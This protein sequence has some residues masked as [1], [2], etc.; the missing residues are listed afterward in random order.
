MQWQLGCAGAAGLC[1]YMD[2]TLVLIGVGP[3]RG[4]SFRQAGGLHMGSAIPCTDPRRCRRVHTIPYAGCMV[5]SRARWTGEWGAG[6]GQAPHTVYN[7]AELRRVHT[8][9]TV[10]RQCRPCCTQHRTLSLPYSPLVSSGSDPAHAFSTPCRTPP[11]ASTHC[12]LC[13]YRHGD[14]LLLAE[15]RRAGH[16]IGD[17]A[18]GAHAGG[19]SRT[20]GG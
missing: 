2:L 7:P 4:L 11:H 10:H 15:D 8:H 13:R 17:A 19:R 5:S 20:P 9:C 1:R 12:T 6:G 3:H 16:C 18:D 14:E